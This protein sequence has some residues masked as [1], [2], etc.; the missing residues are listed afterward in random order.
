M[1]DLT[2]EQW[3]AL[4]PEQQWEHVETLQRFLVER[5]ASLLRDITITLTVET[6]K[7]EQM[8]ETAARETLDA[9]IERWK[10]TL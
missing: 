8:L 6:E 5:K 7:F 4:S 3:D 1:N 9:A 2:K 10:E